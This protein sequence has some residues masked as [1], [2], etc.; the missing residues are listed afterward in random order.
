M[1]LIEYL[2][3]ILRDIYEFKGICGAG[4]IELDKL[5][6]A[7][8]ETVGDN[9]VKSLS[10]G[11]CSRWERMLKLSPKATDTLENRRFRIL[12]AINQDAPYTMRGL[13]NQLSVLCGEGG[14]SAELD[15]AHYRI[16]IRL[17]LSVKEQFSEVQNLLARILPAN[18][19]AA[20]TLKYNQHSAL[21]RYTHGQLAE[22]THETIR[23]EVLT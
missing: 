22:L 20:V 1:K 2:P 5:K 6:A 21:V 12:A 3:D 15:A 7:L 23:S 19:A 9:F 18:I 13:R 16:T 10:E 17:A 14:Y 4:D 8:A 11:G